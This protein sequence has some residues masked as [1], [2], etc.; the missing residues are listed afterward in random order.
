MSKLNDLAWLNL[1][2][3]SLTATSRPIIQKLQ[4]N[5]VDIQHDSLPD[6]VAIKIPDRGLLIKLKNI[7]G[8]DSGEVITDT[9]LDGL[10]QTL[11]V[12]N[13]NIQDLTGI[14]HCSN[15]TKLNIS[16]NE[17]WDISPISNLDK[18][19][20]LEMSHNQISDISPLSELTS[21]IHLYLH[22][23]QISNIKPLSYLDN[24]THLYLGSN[25]IKD[26]SPLLGL[27][28]LDWISVEDNSFSSLS[29]I[30]TINHLQSNGISVNY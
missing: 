17:V 16:G 9:D 24:L 26:I 30:N 6:P 11:D 1:E 2:G 7:L 27:N 15:I 5:G 10:R 21:L 20:V 19:I 29:S 3:N 12:S 14:Q 13:S 4:E 8:K 28:N 25:Q 18:L 23:N 22:E